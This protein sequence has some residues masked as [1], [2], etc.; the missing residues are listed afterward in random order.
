MI[1][2]ISTK[3]DVHAILVKKEL[4]SQGK[5]TRIFDMGEFSYGSFL[6]Y[7]ISDKSPC[8]FVDSDGSK[9]DLTQVTSIWFRRPRYPHLSKI[10][11]RK[12]DRIFGY[13]EWTDATTC[14]LSLDLK[15][16]NQLE[17]QESAKKPKQLEIAKRCGLLVPDTL[18]TNDS[19]K[20]EEFLIEHKNKI[21]HKAMSAPNHRFL[22][23]RLW[24]EEDRRHLFNLELA[25][26]IF[27]NYISGPYDVRSTVIGNEIHSA[28]ITNLNKNGLV[29]SRLDLD[30]PYEA[31]ELPDDIS[32]KI[33]R[34]MEKMGLVFGTIDLKITDKD[35]HV[36]LE[37]NPQGQ[38][39]YVEILTKIPI[40]KTLARYLSE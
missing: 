27:Q 11:A 6:N 17:N 13:R 1:L 5:S 2:I 22:D 4:E 38:F 9:I 18:I 40:V 26:T 23:T 7:Q 10:I 36:F 31:Y 16:V 21:V 19:R 24:T 37:I 25:P 8:E 33:F 29:D 39:L 12:D 15:C 34:F 3:N 30:Q 14:I 20:V 32:N 35:E 28:R